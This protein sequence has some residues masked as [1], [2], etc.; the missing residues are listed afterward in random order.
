MSFD[1]T[2]FSLDEHVNSNWTMTVEAGTSFEDVCN[3]AFFSNVA[4]RLHPYDQIRVRIDTGE[5]YAILLV[6]DCARTWAKVVPL[7]APIK[8][9]AEGGEPAEV[10][11]QYEIKFLGPHK[12][13]CVIRK[14]DKE[15]I[16]EQCATK[17]EA[18]SWLNHYLIAL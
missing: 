1:P 18:H 13:F 5:W 16:K 7:I 17:Q 4:A 14:M 9:V 3:P 6:V 2:R 8:L 11:S 15:A 12:K 10:D